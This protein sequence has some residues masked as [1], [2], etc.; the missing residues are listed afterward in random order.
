MF[1]IIYSIG[2]CGGIYM[3]KAD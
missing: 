2:K 3:K 1:F